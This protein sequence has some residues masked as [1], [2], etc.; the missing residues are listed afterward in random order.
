MIS[1]TAD[2]FKMKSFKICN[3]SPIIDMC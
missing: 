1:E 2:G 3:C